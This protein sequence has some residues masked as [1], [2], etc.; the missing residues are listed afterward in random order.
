VEF[1]LPRINKQHY[2]YVSLERLGLILTIEILI[3]NVNGC[4]RVGVF[5]PL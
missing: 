3:L 1:I 2:S 5:P 4:A